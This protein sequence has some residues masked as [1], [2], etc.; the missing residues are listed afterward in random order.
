MAIG[1][2]TTIVALAVGLML[3][4]VGVALGSMMAVLDNP[5]AGVILGIGLVIVMLIG[6]LILIVLLVAPMVLLMGRWIAAGP[7]LMLEKL[8]PLASL[9]RSWTLTKGRMWRAILYVVLLSL[10]SFIVIG[11]PVSMVQ[12]ITM[13][14]APSH[15]A[16]IAIVSTVVSYALN[17]F[18]QPFYATGVVL[19][20]YDLRVRAEAYD[21]ELRV[22]A[23]EAELAP[24]APPA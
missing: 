7:S 21:V 14:A 22:S 1:I 5:T 4:V 13:I 23:L 2:I 20:Y 10:F 17:L 18:Y 24:D 19:F 16:T 9:Q 6:Y 8:G 11:L 12:W 15:L 3:I